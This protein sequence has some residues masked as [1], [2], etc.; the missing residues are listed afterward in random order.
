MDRNIW[1]N[2]N[3]LFSG[4]LNFRDQDFG[5]SNFTLEQS[6][7]DGDAG[8]EIAY[9][10]QNYERR[11]ATLLSTGRFNAL[12]IDP[13]GYL[14]YPGPNPD[15]SS[16][17]ADLANPNAGRPVA[18]ITGQSGGERGDEQHFFTD[19]EAFR[20]TAYYN[21][22]FTES[23]GFS[24]WFER[25]VLS[26]FYN[27]QDI[28]I[29]TRNVGGYTP[30]VK[31]GQ[32]QACVQPCNPAFAFQYLGPSLLS[33]DITKPGD[34][35]VDRGVFFPSF[36]GASYTAAYWDD[37]ENVWKT[38]TVTETQILDGGTRQ[39][40][41]FESEV[42]S[43]QSYLLEDHLVGLVGWRTDSIQNYSVNASS[44]DRDS[45]GNRPEPADLDLV[46]QDPLADIDSF[47]WSVVG[48]SPWD[49]GD[50]GVSVHYSESENFQPTGL[51]RDPYGNVIGSPQG[52]T[53]E[54][55]VSLELFD[56]MV[57]VRTNWYETVSSL[58]AVPV[59]GAVNGGIA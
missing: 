29:T 24:K 19:R 12:T 4:N 46:K 21:L 36:L 22:D 51:R 54:Y 41:S 50:A 16:G 33:S 31:A 52:T 42:Y 49:I 48:H 27:D 28:E 34:V 53:K 1:D 43:I 15:N 25:H 56:G 45:A 5:T 26:A 9:D 38:G 59:G 58:N 37:F 2:Q 40:D 14:N 30:G 7:L 17:P 47:T 20:A 18:A 8:V 57:F 10:Q 44:F 35:H 23:D 13:N 3:N 11:A 39:L 32:I 6:F 55:G